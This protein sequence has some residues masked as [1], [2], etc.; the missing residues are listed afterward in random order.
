LRLRPRA[1]MPKAQG[2]LPGSA[3]HLSGVSGLRLRRPCRSRR[4]GLADRPGGHGPVFPGR[5]PRRA[6]RDARS[7]WNA[8]RARRGRISAAHASTKHPDFRGAG[9]AHQGCGG[10][11]GQPR[12]PGLHA[13]PFGRARA[14]TC[15]QC[16]RR[17]I[18]R[19]KTQEL[20][21][22][23]RHLA[24]CGSTAKRKSHHV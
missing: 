2:P 1:R 11:G 7:P 14:A 3:F 17:T 23:T 20:R 13:P 18:A 24:G 22:P 10:R 5:R 21:N 12:G 16:N 8:R 19:R 6:G 15:P 9:A 4:H